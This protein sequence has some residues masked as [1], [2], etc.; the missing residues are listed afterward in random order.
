MKFS[1]VGL[2]NTVVHY[3][4]YVICLL[5][6]QKAGLFPSTDYL[7]AQVI[8]FALSV[9]W[10]FYWNRKFVFKADNEKVPWP[11]A[12]L[13]TYIS[14]A[15]TG[16]FLNSVL[17]VLWVQVVHIPKLFA[18]IANLLISVPIN[19]FLNKLWAFRESKRAAGQI[20]T[21]ALINRYISYITDVTDTDSCRNSITGDE[22]YYVA[23]FFY[24][25]I[26]HTDHDG[27]LFRGPASLQVGRSAC[28]EPSVLLAEQPS[29]DRCS[30]GHVR[31]HVRLCAVDSRCE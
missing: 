15:F 2:S 21:Y 10:S 30:A 24:I 28:Y 26:I 14:Y 22:K 16:L 3:V 5:L 13:K 9:L 8:A 11:Q 4:I 7:I 29:D 18:P 31:C 1:V 6:L 19:F 23:G 20:N 12:L 25:F 17:A 27:A